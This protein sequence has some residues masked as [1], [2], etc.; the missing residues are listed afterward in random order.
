MSSTKTSQTYTGELEYNM[1]EDQCYE[2]ERHIRKWGDDFLERQRG[3]GVPEHQLDLPKVIVQLHKDDLK[4]LEN[5]QRIRRE[6]KEYR[7]E[8][9]RVEEEKRWWQE[10]D[11]LKPFR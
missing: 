2:H 5:Y 6:N 10:F 1:L 7:D 3:S 4:R 8:V 9:R 11:I